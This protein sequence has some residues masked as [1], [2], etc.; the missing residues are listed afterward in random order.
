MRASGTRLRPDREC[1]W[2]PGGL[3]DYLAN[4][5]Q[6]IERYGVVLDLQSD[7]NLAIEESPSGSLSFE[8]RGFLPGGNEPPRSILALREIWRSDPA[9]SYFERSEYE[10][11]LIDRQRDLRRA[12]HLHDAS[13][14]IKRFHVV[15]HEH[16]ERP[17]GHGRCP[18]FA[19][20]PVR[21]AFHGVELL[22]GAWTDPSGAD[23]RGLKC[24]Q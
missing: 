13:V 22:V 4:V 11:E 19:G 21:D 23:C 12:Y 15:V 17:I 2:T 6:L 10:Y 7:D 1:V 3:A 16:C 18:H 8:I 5:A 14:F 9:S 20:S 24:L